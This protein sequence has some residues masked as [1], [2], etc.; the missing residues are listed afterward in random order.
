MNILTKMIKEELNK[1]LNEAKTF[2][3][4]DMWSKDFD[5]KGMMKFASTAKVGMGMK[6][7][8]LLYNSLEDVNY[9]S[10]NSLLGFALGHLEHGNKQEADKLMKQFN[11]KAKATLR[12][13]REGL[14]V[15]GTISLKESKLNEAKFYITYNKG[16][17][18]GKALIK[19]SASNWKRPQVFNSYKDA[20][21]YIGSDNAGPSLTA[22]W[23]SDDKMNRINKYGELKEGK[24]TEAL[25]RGLKPLL[26]IGSTIKSNAGE[27]ALVKLSDKFDK[28]DDEQADDVASHLNMAIEL[29]QDRSPSEARAW[30]K[31]FNKACKDALSGKSIKSAFEGVNEQTVTFTKD[32]MGALHNDGKIT[33]AD[34]EG[35]D[36]VYLYKEGT[37][38][39]M[40]EKYNTTSH[41]KKRLGQL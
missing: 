18:Q 39:E 21:T 25:A 1:Q 3:P 7:L 32:E 8:E 36:H 34:A 19:S 38:V 5:Y 16:R 28:I 20:E 24:L 30:L 29:M 35:K 14:S 10:E 9:H 41:W 11:T 40:V 17:G 12:T 37:I 22:Y 23:V 13:I 26:T 6:K 33:K 31:K 15:E 4:G 2:K 27:S